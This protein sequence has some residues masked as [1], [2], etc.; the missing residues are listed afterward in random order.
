MAVHTKLSR[1]DILEILKKYNLGNLE[2]FS[3]I[4]EG[5]EN[6]NYFII[7]SKNK[8]VLTIYENRVNKSKL[9][10][11]LKLMIHSSAQKIKCPNPI[12][13]KN[14]GLINITKSKKF[15]IF[16]FLDGKSKKNWVDFDCLLVGNDLANF[17]KKNMKIKLDIDN[18]YGV[19][20][21]EKLFN[22]CKFKIEKI[23]PN[24]LN[25]ISK[26]I[27]YLN[28]EWPNDLPT[29]LI[30]GDLFPDN[31]LFLNNKI[32]G[33]LD[34][35]FSCNEILV[36]DLAITLNAWGFRNGKFKK[37]LFFKLLHG[38]QTV[39]KLRKCEKQKLNILLRGASMRFLLTRIYDMIYVDANKFLNKKNPLEFFKIL[40]FH[41]E[42]NNSSDYFRGI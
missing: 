12:K 42:T 33:I 24:S 26:E 39:R 23:I 2:K 14:K 9:P 11:F 41:K 29:G 17:H 20:S 16:S 40:N 10:M 3:G 32:S 8:F 19:S 30:H 6:T 13:D 22:K 27:E 28:K 36:Y 1:N 4:K 21:W 18:S 15:G 38:Y 31:V 7:T 35:Y 37:E 34:F 25:L 5:I